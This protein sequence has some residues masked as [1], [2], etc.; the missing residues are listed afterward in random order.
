MSIEQIA[1]QMDEEMTLPLGRMTWGTCYNSRSYYGHKPDKL[2]SGVQKY[3]RRREE[4]KMLWCIGEIYLFKFADPAAKTM[5]TNLVNRLII[6]LD[7]EIVFSEW[8]N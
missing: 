5:I 3:L 4:K 1:E 2:K 8:A 7:E 6:M